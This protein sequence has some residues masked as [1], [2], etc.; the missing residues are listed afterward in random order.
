MHSVWKRETHFRSTRTWPDFD[1]W[2][3]IGFQWS[4]NWAAFGAIF[5]LH[6]F[7]MLWTN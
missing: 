7:D 2:S 6:L 3:R 4:W 5:I 1:S